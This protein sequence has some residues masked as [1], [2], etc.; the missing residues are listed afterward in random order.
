MCA[1]SGVQSL[2]F[3]SVKI[4]LLSETFCRNW[5]FLPRPRHSCASNGGDGCDGRQ[6]TKIAVHLSSSLRL[7]SFCFSCIFQ[8]NFSVGKPYRCRFFSIARCKLCCYTCALASHNAQGS[9][10]SFEP[11]VER[12][13]Q[14][15]TQHDRSLK[16]MKRRE[17]ETSV[18]LNDYATAKCASDCLC[19]PLPPHLP[20]FLVRL[21]LMHHRVIT[22]ASLQSF[23]AGV[24]VLW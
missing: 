17:C 9:S 10:F 24:P 5:K 23:S 22:T 18:I 8:T 20:R 2:P 21:S 14:S 13:A 19:G 15:C 4:H 12:N 7:F 16:Q 3:T 1:R 6:Y 11:A